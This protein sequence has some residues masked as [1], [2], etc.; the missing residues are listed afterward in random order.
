MSVELILSI[1]I[2]Q[3]KKGAKYEEE[4]ETKSWRLIMKWKN[5]RY[6]INWRINK[7]INTKIQLSLSKIISASAGICFC[8]VQSLQMILQICIVCLIFLNNN[9]IEKRISVPTKLFKNKMNDST[10]SYFRIKT[11]SQ[12]YLLEIWLMRPKENRPKEHWKL[13]RK[14]APNG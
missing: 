13:D 1:T 2:L 5:E 4:K 11:N 9:T 6:V 10:A 3:I 14:N 12:R 7:Y 8:K